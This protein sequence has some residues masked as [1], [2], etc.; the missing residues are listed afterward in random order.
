M[1]LVMLTLTAMSAST[2]CLALLFLYALFVP[3]L[4][5]PAVSLTGVH[6]ARFNAPVAQPLMTAA[7][8]VR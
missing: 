7:A 6:V 3:T 2:A 4:P 8:D 5:P 1:R